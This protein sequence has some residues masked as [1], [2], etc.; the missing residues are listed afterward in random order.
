[1][2]VKSMFVGP[3]TALSLEKMGHQRKTQQLLLGFLFVLPLILIWDLPNKTEVPRWLAANL[4]APA[5]LLVWLFTSRQGLVWG[6]LHFLVT[7]VLGAT[8]LLSVVHLDTPGVQA[9]LRQQVTLTLFFFFGA[10]YFSDVSARR[11][12]LQVTAA[13]GS[14]IAL[15][16]IAQH[17]SGSNLGLPATSARARAVAPCVRIHVASPSWGK[18]E[19]K[20]GAEKRNQWPVIQ[21]NVRHPC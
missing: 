19:S 2:P 3:V 8:L 17:L 15:I 5:I 10:A 11:S 12:L 4:F 1:M 13:V 6:R 16:G 14:L 21:K 18:L 20:Q 7:L 9:A